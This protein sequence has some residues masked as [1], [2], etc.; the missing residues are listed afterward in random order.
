MYKKI[1]SYQLHAKIDYLKISAI[2]SEEF[3]E[4]KIVNGITDSANGSIKMHHRP[5]LKVCN[6]IY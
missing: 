3:T 6:N 1:L 2:I 5:F 4:S